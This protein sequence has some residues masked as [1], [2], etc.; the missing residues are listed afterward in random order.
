MPDL[1][2]IIVRIALVVAGLG[3]WFITQHLI[4]FRPTGTGRIG[5]GIHTLT[6]R[7]N[8]YLNEH[9]KA[10]DALLILSSLGIDLLGLFV[11]YQSIFGPSVR[12]FV[13]LMILFILRQLCQAVS[14]L[15]IPEGM[16]WRSPGVPSLLVTYGV[17]ND[18]FFSGHTAL[19]VFGATE[20]GLWGGPA[21]AIV[22]GV[23]ALFEVAAVLVLRAHFTMDV[24]AGAVTSV[25]AT[26]A[27]FAVGPTVD[28]WMSRLASAIA[29]IG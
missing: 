8:R 10:A 29:P 14:A 1:P 20:L 6:W 5:D 11:F 27:S 13:G 2:I 21:W 16:I 18:L 25:V 28:E 3:I 15:P 4:T 17:A 24:Y 9:P 22:G 19:A 23:I 12:P 7:C 26:W